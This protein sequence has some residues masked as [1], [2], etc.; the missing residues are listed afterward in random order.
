[1]PNSASEEAEVTSSIHVAGLHPSFILGTP[2]IPYS[3][4]KE[5]ERERESL[6]H[7]SENIYLK[8]FDHF[9]GALSHRSTIDHA[10][11]S[12]HK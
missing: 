2:E 6:M 10:P 12:F 11:S 9:R 4:V 7:T 1:M 3:K 8:I 5:L